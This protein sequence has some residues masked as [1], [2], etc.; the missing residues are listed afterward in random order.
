MRDGL[1]PAL[2]GLICLGGCAAQPESRV[3]TKS[4][5][6]AVQATAPGR[7]QCET[8]S[9]ADTATGAAATNRMRAAHGLAPLRGNALL[10]RVAARHAC[11]MAQRGLMTHIGSTSSGPLARAKRAGYG[12][13]LAAENIAAG[14]FDLNRVLREWNASHKH[15][16][17]IMIPQ[18]RDYGIGRAVGA[19]GKTV[20]WA[21]V[22]AMPKAR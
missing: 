2:I 22:Y 7:A 21:A 6:H 15:L 18:T 8:T 17:N 10:S 9:S 5:P 12:P 20:F 13:R 1:A 14:P 16:D 3:S 19:D 11:D 4:D